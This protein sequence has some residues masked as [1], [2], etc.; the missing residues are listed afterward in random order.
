[1]E[2]SMEDYDSAEDADS[3]SSDDEWYF[4]KYL[5]IFDIKIKYILF[6]FSKLYSSKSL[7][8]SLFYFINSKSHISSN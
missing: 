7:Y 4:F 8:I 6:K 1:M 5:T 2:E 3:E